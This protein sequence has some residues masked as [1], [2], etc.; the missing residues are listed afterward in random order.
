MMI[1]R[2]PGCWSRLRVQCNEVRRSRFRPPAS[3]I[4]VNDHFHMHGNFL[5]GPPL[6]C[7]KMKKR[8]TSQPEAL[9][10]EGFI[11]LQF[12]LARWHFFISVLNHLVDKNRKL[13]SDLTLRN[14]VSPKSANNETDI[15]RI[16]L[17]TVARKSR[18]SHL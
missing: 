14:I 12:R 9:S 17:R 2:P 4:L 6:F 8:L 1:Q 13:I 11:E 15:A 7:A 18:T 5:T 16:R 10:G 3:E